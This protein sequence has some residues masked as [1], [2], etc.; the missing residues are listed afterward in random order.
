[1]IRSYSWEIIFQCSEVRNYYKC[2]EV[3]L[4]TLLS[5]TWSVSCEVFPS[6]H[7]WSCKSTWSGQASKS[8]IYYAYLF[9]FNEN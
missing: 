9:F 3:Q 4:K 6:K 5:A 1:M 8:L 2:S 7:S